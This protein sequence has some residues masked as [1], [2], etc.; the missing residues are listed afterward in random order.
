MTTSN[1]LVHRTLWERLGGFAPYRYVHDYD[2]LLRAA[3]MCPSRVVYA[4]ELR[5]V[6]YRIH[7]SNTIAENTERALA[8]RADM[9]RTL[10]RP[11]HRVR[12]ALVRS[13]SG[14]V[15]RAAVDASPIIAP[16]AHAHAASEP[17]LRVG[18]VARSLGVGGLEEVVALLA[19]SL[20][21]EGVTVSVLCTDAGGSTAERL[22]AAGVDVTVGDGRAQ[23]WRD[24]HARARPDVL[25]THFVGEDVFDALAPHCPVVDTVHNTY[26]WLGPEEWE[27]LARQRRAVAATIAVSELAARHWL[28]RVGAAEARLGGAVAPGSAPAVHVVPNAVHPAR[29]AR[30]PRAYARRGLGIPA[31][32]PLFVHLGRVTSQ[33][34]LDGLLGAFADA[35]PEM[36]AARLLLVGPT[37][38][39]GAIAGLE[40]AH[41]E[42]FRA[43]SVRRLPPRE[44]VGVVLSAA[45]ALVSSSFYEG[46]SISASEALWVGAPVVLA[47]CGGAREL[48]GASG[49][50][51]FVVAHPLGDPLAVSPELLASPPAVALA[52]HRG[53]LAAALARFSAGRPVEVAPDHEIRSWARRRLAPGR[54]AADYASILRSVA[55]R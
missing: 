46:W 37:D 43:G 40:R 16:R 34:N 8:E 4:P 50:R 52:K 24:W 38:D 26:A 42:L 31:D 21:A 55:R 13:R 23:S 49:E 39:R 35:L 45:D 54:L 12:A 30:V 2:F 33:K 10:R 36:P 27:A 1:F 11:A 18:L 20:P 25:S 48:A 3:T 19:Q 6:R 17:N 29:A 28:D 51:G 47:D 9:L 5:D 53:E 41:G 32:V 44:V 15:V 7:A 14:P 22:R